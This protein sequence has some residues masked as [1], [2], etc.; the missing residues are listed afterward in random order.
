M[1]RAAEGPRG[2]LSR[3]LRC[4]AKQVR[5]SGLL[6]RG[7]RATAPPRRIHHRSRGSHLQRPQGLEV[8]QL[9]REDR[10]WA[11]VD[12]RGCG[13]LAHRR[14][15]AGGRRPRPANAADGPASA[16]GEHAQPA[17]D[18]GAAA[19]G[20]DARAG[21]QGRRRRRGLGRAL[22]R[23]DPRRAAPGCRAGA[24]P[25]VRQGAPRRL[26]LPAR[27]LG[28]LE[29]GRPRAAHDRVRL[30]VRLAGVEPPRRGV[31]R[32]VRLRLAPEEPGRGV[33]GRPARRR[34]AQPQPA[35]RRPGLRRARPP[36]TGGAVVRSSRA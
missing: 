31:D 23:A 15:R 10:R 22:R 29:P 21:R 27:E 13:T 33:G 1:C 16:P 11:A 3:L 7:Q 28:A 34:P 8:G 6:R 25:H 17:R 36:P 5:G 2:R 18:P 20:R 14:A 12:D 4:L 32:L 26:G 19:S 24:P 9:R 30:R 35:R